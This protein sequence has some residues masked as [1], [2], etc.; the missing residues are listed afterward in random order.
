MLQENKWVAFI[1]VFLVAAVLQVAFIFA[2]CRQT[3]T[4]TAIAFSKAYFELDD[5]MGGHICSEL[6]QG[7][8]VDIVAE[9]LAKKRAEASERGIH[10]GMVRRTLYHIHTE[11]INQ[12][13]ESAKIVLSG[14]TR[15]SINPVFTWVAKIFRLG[16]TQEVHTIINLVN[17]EG[18]WKVCGAPYDLLKDA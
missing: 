5:A 14:T 3:A 1:L 2:D 18:R 4:G 7:E 13:K 17:E 12:D 6:A 11:T 10:M 9:Y 16:E 15:V 8:D